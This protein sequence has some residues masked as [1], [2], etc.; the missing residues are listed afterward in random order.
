MAKKL[1][2]VFVP[3]IM[4]SSLRRTKGQKLGVWEPDI[5]ANYRRLS[6]EPDVLI[7]DE[8]ESS[9]I[10]TKFKA[11]H[12][13][14]V[15]FYESILR[16]LVESPQ[17]T[18]NPKVFRGY[19]DWR[20]SN[21]DSA[22]E[23]VERFR[24]LHKVNLSE[25]QEGLKLTFVTHSMGALVV[26]LALLDGL[27]H[28]DNVETIVH[29][30]PPLAGAP[31]AFRSMINSDALPFLQEYIWLVR[32]YW[33][34]NIANRHLVEALTQFPSTYELLPP[35]ASDY[36]HL[37]KAGIGTT[38]V[39]NPLYAKAMRKPLDKALAGKARK[40]HQKLATFPKRFPAKREGGKF[41]VHTVYCDEN[42]KN[43]TDVQYQAQERGDWYE[44][45]EPVPFRIAR[46]GDGTVPAWSS[47]YMDGDVAHRHPV[48]GCKHDVMCA[49]TRVLARLGYL[50]VI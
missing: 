16:A 49:N 17:Y 9:D 22:R 43:L 44:L 23:V 28:A 18:A 5:L 35:K 42:V 32:M 25:P 39:I 48:P 38:D 7:G 34:A 1:G 2:A 31:N 13:W 45:V 41:D 12:V 4:G 24:V 29:I 37:F 27:I 50:G 15:D 26:R 33:D 40:V 19:Y 10:I 20:R 46:R 30:A 8:I 47:T 14:G 21:A 3:G 6:G 11:L 36:L